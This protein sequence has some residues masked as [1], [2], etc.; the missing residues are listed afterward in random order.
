MRRETELV[1]SK[2][3]HG[4]L[5]FEFEFEQELELGMATARRPSWS[6]PDTRAARRARLTCVE[7]SPCSEH[8]SRC[9]ST[10]RYIKTVGPEL[11]GTSETHALAIVMA[12]CSRLPGKRQ[13]DHPGTSLVAAG[14][15]AGCRQAYTPAVI[16]NC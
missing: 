8:R 1:L 7:L 10:V 9:V 12:T 3:L 15:C 13:P 6:G 11:E 14:L 2:E 4:E 16:D 5:E